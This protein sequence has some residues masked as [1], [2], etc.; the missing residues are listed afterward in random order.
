MIILLLLF[1]FTELFLLL[2]FGCCSRSGHLLVEITHSDQSER[3]GLVGDSAAEPIGPV[4]PP[5]KAELE[6]MIVE[7]VP[8]LLPSDAMLFKLDVELLRDPGPAL[9][10]FVAFSMLSINDLT[11]SRLSCL[12]RPTF[13][14]RTAISC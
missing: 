1:L 12:A 11:D 8:T 10:C 7:F 3:I 6:P 9:A 2:P 14:R 13:C 4:E 5:R